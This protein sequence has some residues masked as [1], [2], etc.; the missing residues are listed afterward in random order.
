MNNDI[1]FIAPGI[2]I[3]S[4]VVGRPRTNVVEEREARDAKEEPHDT[5]HADGDAE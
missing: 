4:L 5:Q 3:R 2:T 1:L